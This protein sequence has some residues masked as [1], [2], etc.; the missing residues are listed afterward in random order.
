MISKPNNWNDIKASGDTKKLVPGGYVAII[1]K[2]TDVTDK[3]YLALEYD[4]CEGEYKGYA[5][6]GFE[7]WGNWPLRFIRSYKEKALSMFKGF[8]EA[9]ESTNPGFTFD[10]NNP[11]CLTNRGVGIVLGEEEYYNKDNE[12]RT[13]L[14]VKSFTTAGKIREGDFKIPELKKFK[15]EPP[16]TASD[17]GFEP[18]QDDGTLPF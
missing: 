13:R 11:A 8:I 3:E 1:R 6:D 17:Y 18:V 14:Y 9:V 5:V 15:G 12:L 2:V 10:W 4:I 7:R 16:K